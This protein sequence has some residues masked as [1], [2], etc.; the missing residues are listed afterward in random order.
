VDGEGDWPRRGDGDRD[1]FTKSMLELGLSD[2][3]AWMF[4]TLGV[5]GRGVGDPMG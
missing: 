1:W 3:V 2:K 4:R 5:P